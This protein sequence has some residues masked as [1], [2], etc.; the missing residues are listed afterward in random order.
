[1]K[2][3]RLTLLF[4]NDTG[5]GKLHHFLLVFETFSDSRTE[6]TNEKSQLMRY[7]EQMKQSILEN[8]NYVDA[9]METAQAV[10]MVDLT[11]DRLEKFFEQFK[12]KRI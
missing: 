4:G 2:R 9:L 7:Y 1:M 11:H 5:E 12:R 3:G 8:G 6:E 10:Y